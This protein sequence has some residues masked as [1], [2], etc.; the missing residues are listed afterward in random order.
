[1]KAVIGEI[2]IVTIPIIQYDE[3]GDVGVLLQKRPVLILDDGRG[4]IV[5]EDKRNYHVLKLTTQKDSYKRKEIKNWR[6]LGLKRKSYIRIEMPIK[7][8]EQQFERKVATL[9]EKQL[10]EMYSEV[11]GILN[12]KALEKMAEKYKEDSK[13][14]QN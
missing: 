7:L 3:N 9:P 2:W 1:M 6:E 8:E 4:L 10:L 5:E 14:S 12:I 13:Q 11:Y